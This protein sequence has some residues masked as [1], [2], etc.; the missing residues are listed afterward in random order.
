MSRQEFMCP[1]TVK[2]S[3]RARHVRFVVSADGLAVVVPNRFCVSRDLPPMLEEK[4]DWIV[5]ALKKVADRAKQKAETNGVPDVIDL[6]ALE[7]QWRVTFASL[8]G[9]VKER[10]TEENG[11]ITLTPDFSENEAIA[12]LNR[13]LRVKGRGHL[14]RLLGE[15]AEPHRFS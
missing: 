8:A 15:E 4:K 10:L 3:A 14:P 5:R 7:K 12:A 11:T 13:W 9:L 1:Y 6:R 2:R